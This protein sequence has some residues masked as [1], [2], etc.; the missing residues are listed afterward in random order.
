LIFAKYAAAEKKKKEIEEKHQE[1]K[2]TIGKYLLA[3]VLMLVVAAATYYFVRP[4]AVEQQYSAPSDSFKDNS[5]EP[6]RSVA[7]EEKIQEK[8]PASPRQAAEQAA[9]SPVERARMATVSIETPWG[10]GSGFFVKQ[11]YIVTN[12]HVVEFDQEDLQ[13]IREKI[14]TNRQLI[15]LEEEKLR[16]LRSRLRSMPNGPGKSQLEIIIRER[17]KNLVKVTR[18]QEEG[19]S[20]L[21][22]LEKDIVSPRIS[23]ILS[24][25]AEHSAGYILTSSKYDLALLALFSYDGREL[26]LPPQG[27]P[28]RQ[29]DKVYTVGS[30]VGLRHSVT[31]GVFSGFRQ[32]E[33]DQ[34]IFLQ[35][36]AAINPGNS[37]GPLIDENGYV[38]GVNTMILQNTEGIGFAIPIEKVFEEFGSTLQ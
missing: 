22:Q 38:R 14:S 10:T 8:Q 7:V 24:D 25:G 17:E 3:A 11:N 32:R 5:V 15:D 28:L 18:Q 19:E 36:D 34:Q 21:A 29:G 35:T 23:I 9:A 20:R 37:G 27:V 26:A 16:E 13:E 31:A 6:A 1:K 30:P 12:K 33:T 2:S 4:G